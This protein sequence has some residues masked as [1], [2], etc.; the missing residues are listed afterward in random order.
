MIFDYFS[1]KYIIKVPL[2]VG[3]FYGKSEELHV[4]FL[5]VSPY[6]MGAIFNFRRRGI[7]L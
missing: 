7:L 6:L 2:T 3:G 1:F 4:Q 5:N